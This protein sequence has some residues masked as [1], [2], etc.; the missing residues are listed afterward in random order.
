M[1]AIYLDYHEYLLWNLNFTGLCFARL[2]RRPPVALSQEK[3]NENWKRK[4]QAL[5][6]F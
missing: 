4:K 5:A 1:Y 2:K 3:K 6:L